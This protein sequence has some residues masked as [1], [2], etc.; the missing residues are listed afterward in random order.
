VCVSVSLLPKYWSLWRI[1]RALL[2]ECSFSE[3]VGP[4]LG[5]IGLFCG[6]IGLFGGDVWF[7]GGDISL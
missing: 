1:Y 7:F 2:L 6:D 5:N 3:D 4:W